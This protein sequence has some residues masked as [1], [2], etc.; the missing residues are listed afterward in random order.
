M[1]G[2]NG[3]KITVYNYT[4]EKN[5]LDKN[6]VN[7]DTTYKYLTT[8]DTFDGSARDAVDVVT[9]SIAVAG[10]VKAGNYAYVDTTGFYYWIESKNIV[11]DN[12][13]VLSLRRDPLCSF[14]SEIK[15]CPCVCDRTADTARGTFYIHDAA[16]RTNQY[17]YDETISL[18]PNTIFGY[19]GHILLMTVG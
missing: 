6:A 8:V 11:R 15:A 7:P 5:R 12:Y 16:L 4:A 14:Q 2:V 1:W 9:P 13:T 19:N 10:N 17:T 3:M 18:K